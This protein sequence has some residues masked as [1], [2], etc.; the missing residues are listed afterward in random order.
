MPTDKKPK[1]GSGKRFKQGVDK[2]KKEGK[3]PK[4]AAAIM[5]SAG[6]AKFGAAKMSSMAATG[7]RR[8]ARKK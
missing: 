1:L 7:R 3:S 8:A 6:R 5:A 4:A 2:L